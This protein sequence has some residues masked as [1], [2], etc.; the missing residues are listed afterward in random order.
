MPCDT[1]RDY[2]PRADLPIIMNVMRRL[3]SAL[4]LVSVLQ[5]AGA[6]DVFA[7]FPSR[8]RVATKDPQVRL[9]WDDS[10]DL[11]G[12]YLVYRHTEEITAQNL[13]RAEL[14]GAV[15]EGVESLIDTPPEPGS[16][17]YAV[18][19]QDAEGTI[20]EVVV[21]FRNATVSPV[22]VENPPTEA[23]RAAQVRNIKAAPSDTT[24][25]VRFNSGRTDRE[26][27][28]YRS[29]DPI[30]TSE[31]LANSTRIA[32]VSSTTA[33]FVDYPV[34]GVGYHYAVIDTELIAEGK[35]ELVT[36][37]NT[38]DDP[39]EIALPE[40]ARP[41]FEPAAIDT[42][43]RARSRPLPFY[44]IQG[45]VE[46]GSTILGRSSIIVPE[47]R[48]IAP[49]TDKA[50]VQLIRMANRPEPPA[51]TLEV[52]DQDTT[53]PTDQDGAKGMELTL[54]TVV[55]GPLSRGAWSEAIT[56]LQNFVRL[57]LPDELTHRAYFYLGQAYYFNQD[58]RKAALAFLTA[59]EDYY[60]Q[61]TRWLDRSLR[62][63]PSE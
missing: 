4:L 1:D 51:P 44:Q 40:Q 26:L 21:P 14:V 47:R 61:A 27:A 38:T 46:R 59:Q 12:R 55:E 11:S 24:I 6:Q 9:S 3:L 57:P 58:Y 20:Y 25:T 43:G 54:R 35:I 34:P 13:P 45:A 28:V 16:Y 41:A 42:T 7:P 36:G 52:L 37:E 23:D 17:Y 32:Q 60:P 31:D 62:A 56:M 29:V 50:V 39:V 63:F 33:E 18:L 49:E 48:E 30:R 53:T 8:I 19:A 5:L 15:D 22:V 10:T 2:G